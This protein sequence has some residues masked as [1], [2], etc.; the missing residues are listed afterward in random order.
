MHPVEYVEVVRRPVAI[1]V[2][3]KELQCGVSRKLNHGGSPG[4]DA[5]VHCMECR[6]RATACYAAGR[7]CAECASAA[8]VAAHA[9]DGRDN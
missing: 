1:Q 5:T 6:R 9:D 7:G 8:A 2:S 3:F 4:L